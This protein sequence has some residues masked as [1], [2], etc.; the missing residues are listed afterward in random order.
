MSNLQFTVEQFRTSALEKLAFLEGNGFNH[1]PSLEQTS[2]T[3]G[4]IVYLGKH[5]GFVF[6]LDVRDQCVDAQVVKVKDG[7][8][9]RNWEGGYS[10]DIFSH[11]VKYAGYRGSAGGSRKSPNNDAGQAAIQRMIDGWAELLKKSGQS[12]LSDKPESLPV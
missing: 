12:L 6:S 4:T 3:S 10:S 7:Q 11:L 9:K 2:P 1:V 8:M 5:V